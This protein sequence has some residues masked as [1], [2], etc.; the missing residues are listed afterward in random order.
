MEVDHRDGNGLNNR[1]CNIR[2]AT[3]EENRRNTKKRLG[4]TS[5]FKGVYRKPSGRFV[6]FICIR[7]KQEYIGSF[8]NEFEAAR[9]YNELAKK[10]FGEFAWLNEIPSS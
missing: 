7:G 2:S 4:C 1:R 9:T 6:V 10:E 3:T 8:T 5:L